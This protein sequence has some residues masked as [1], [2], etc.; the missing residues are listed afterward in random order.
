MNAVLREMGLNL[1][2]SSSG[3]RNLLHEDCSSQT[4]PA[5]SSATFPANTN[6]ISHDQ[7]LSLDALG[8]SFLDCHAKMQH[9]AGVI[10][11]QD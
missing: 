9:V 3:S 6:V 11:N 8:A 5:N 2:L 1:P 10:H 7:K 4:S